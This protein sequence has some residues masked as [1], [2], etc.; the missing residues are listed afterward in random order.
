GVRKAS[1]NFPRII[2]LE[3]IKILNLKKNLLKSNPMCKKCNKKMKSKGQNQGF[4]CIRCG[5]RKSIKITVE[6]PRKIQK[7]LYVP[8]MS[9]HRHLTRPL[10]RIGM[11]NKVSK[12]DES[13]SWFCTYRN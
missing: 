12:F 3:F 4:Q 10:Q 1:K 5:N 6:I 2:N 9:A 8:E 11:T 7:Q 13:L